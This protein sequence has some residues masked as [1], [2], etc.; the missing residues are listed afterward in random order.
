MKSAAESS[1]FPIYPTM[2]GQNRD[3][4]GPAPFNTKTAGGPGSLLIAPAVFHLTL[5]PGARERL[6]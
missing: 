6:E 3:W 2:A 1:V 4:A 5:C